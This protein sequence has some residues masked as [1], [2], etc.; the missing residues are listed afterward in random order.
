MNTATLF[1]GSNK[2]LLKTML[3]TRS[4]NNNVRIEK[5]TAVD[6]IHEI[7]TD[8]VWFENDNIEDCISLTGKKRIEHIRLQTSNI[9]FLTDPRLKHIKGI[10]FQFEVENIEPLFLLSHLT[11]LNLPENIKIDFDFSRFRNLIYLGGVLPKKNVNLNQL[12]KLKYT[13]LFNYKKEDL[14]EFSDCKD[15]RRLWIYSLQIK[16]LDGLSTLEK[17]NY[18]YLDN[19]REL[20]TLDG[21]G[22]K[23]IDLQIFHLSN[24]KKLQNANSLEKLPNLKQLSLYKTPALESLVFLKNL[25]N[26]ESLGLH[27]N[28]V[29]VKNNDYYPLVETLQRLNKLDNLNSWK[30]L[31]NYLDKKIII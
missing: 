19:C 30:P 10:T 20:V 31:K 5:L 18:V 15:L 14:R 6:N 23:N 1:Y 16:S 4:F 21:I 29:G 11:H 3:G 13:S 2:I 12:T 26:L 22:E 27:P 9:D 17:L 25:Y 24:S 28:N 7:K 8:T